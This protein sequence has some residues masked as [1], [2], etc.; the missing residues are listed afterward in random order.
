[1]FQQGMEILNDLFLHDLN[2]VQ[3]HF[4][5]TIDETMKNFYQCKKNSLINT[6]V[7]RIDA[8]VAAVKIKN[9]L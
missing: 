9:G 7:A 1:M 4:G 6:C 2:I 5:L 3:E 8:T